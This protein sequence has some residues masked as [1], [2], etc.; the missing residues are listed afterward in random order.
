[1]MCS[2]TILQFE[3]LRTSRGVQVTD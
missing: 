2:G 3:V 1:M